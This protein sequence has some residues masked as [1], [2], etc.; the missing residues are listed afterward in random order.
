[1]EEV[2]QKD[3]FQEFGFFPSIIVVDLLVKQDRH[4]LIGLSLLTLCFSPETNAF[5]YLCH[6]C[7]E[8]CLPD[9]IVGHLYSRDH[10]SNYF[11]YTDPNV[12]SFSWVPSMD[13]RVILRAEILREVK[14]SGP[15]Q[16][17]VLD[18][19]DN[20]LK[21][22]QRSTY[23]DV[24]RTLSDNDKLL[25]LIEAGKPKRMM[26]QTYQKDNHRKHPLLGMQHLVECI[27]LGSAER[28]YY[29]CTLCKL[30][31]ATHMIIRHVLSFDHIFNY[32]KE[33]HPSTLMPKEC[34]KDYSIILDFAKQSEEIHGTA[35]MK[36][37][38]LKPPKFTSV[39]FTCYAK[40]LKDL[41][42]IADEN[43]ES[44]LIAS[45]K[46]GNKLEPRTVSAP[47][48]EL[49]YK[50]RCQDCSV[51]FETAFQYFKHL[52][53]LLH[54][55]M[56]E[57][58]FVKGERADDCHRKVGPPSVGLYK[59][60]KN[61][62]EQNNPAIGVSLVVTCISTE[63]QVEPL[64][65][66]FACEDCFPE[67]FLRKHFDSRKHLI[68]TLL[69]QNPW[70]LPF[71]WET[72]DVNALKS[73]A[74]EEEKERGPDEMMLKVLDMPYSMFRGLR[75]SYTEVMSSLKLHHV[76][77][78]REVPL[79]QT[80]RKLHQN[81]RFPLLG[82][83]FLVMYD[84]CIKQHQTAE[85]AFLCLLCARKLSNEE[86]YAH[87]F[88][89]EHVATFLNHFHPGSL[90]SS[91]DAETLLDL[92]KQAG[93]T[94]SISRVQIIKLDKPIWAPCTYERAISILASAKSRNG[95]GKLEPRIIP[96]VKLFPRKI[97]K[98][99]DK[100]HVKDNS[101]ANNRILEG[102]EKQTSEM[103]LKK[104]SAEVG[105]EIMNTLDV[106][107][108]VNSEKRSDEETLTQSEDE[109]K[110][111]GSETCQ[112]MKEEKTDNPTVSGETLE[113]CQNT[114]KAHET[115]ESFKSKDASKQLKDYMDKSHEK[116]QDDTCS[117]EE[118]EKKTGYKWQEL[119]LPQNP[120]TQNLPSNDQ[121][122][123]TTAEGRDQAS[124]NLNHQGVELWRY[125]KRKSREP[126][127]G[128]GALV[129]C[130]CDQHDPIYLCECCCLKIPEKEVISHVT[131]SGHQ[132][133]F[134][135]GLK[136]LQL[137][138]GTQSFSH[139]AA[140][141]EQDNG[142]GEAEVVELDE[143][144]YSNI[145][146]LNFKSAVQTVKAQQAQ[147]QDSRHDLS[148]TSALSAVQPMDTFVTLHAQHEV[149]SVTDDSQM[150]VEMQTDEDSEASEVQPSSLTGAVTE[151]T[152]KAAEVPADSNE[153]VKMTQ[154]KVSE[155]AANA[156]TCLTVSR[157]SEDLSSGPVT[158]CL[159]P[160]ST[161][162]SLK[163][164]VN[165]NKSV[166]TLKIKTTSEIVGTSQYAV[167]ST[168]SMTA[169]SQCST[170]PP[171]STSGTTK[172]TAPNSSLRASTS[173]CNITTPTTSKSRETAHRCATSSNAT[174]T[175]TEQTVG[176]NHSSLTSKTANAYRNSEAASQITVASQTIVTSI[177]SED[178]E[179]SA[180]TAF[181]NISKEPN[182]I[183]T[184][185]EASHSTMHTSVE[186]DNRNS[187]TMPSQSSTSRA[188]P[189]SKHPKVGVN[190]LIVVT[191]K[192]KQQVYC[193]LCSVKVDR[194]GSSHLNSLPHKYNYVKMLPGCTHSSSQLESRLDKIVA[195]L[196]EVEKN[197]G[198][199]NAQTIEVTSDV[200]KELNTLPKDNALQ[201]LKEMLKEKTTDTVEEK[202]PFAS[203]CD[204]SSSDDGMH[205]PQNEMAELSTDNQSENNPE[206]QTPLVQTPA[207]M[208]RP[209]GQPD[210]LAN[211]SKATDG[212]SQTPKLCQ[213]TA[214][215]RQLERSDS[216]LTDTQ[217]V[218]KDTQKTSN[219]KL[220]SPDPLPSAAPVNIEQQNQSRLSQRAEHILKH[221]ERSTGPGHHSASLALPRISKGQSTQGRSHLST[222]L[223]VKGHD[224][225]LIIGLSSVWECRG[226]S[227]ASFYL[228]ESCRETLFIR[229][230][231]EHMVSETHQL[232]YMQRE[233]SRYLWFRQLKDLT[234]TEKDYI[235]KKV[236][237]LISQAECSNNMDAQVI[238]LRPDLYNCVRTAPFSEALKLVHKIR[239]EPYLSVICPPVCTLQQNDQLPEN[240][241]SPEES[242]PTEK[243]STQALETDQRSDNEEGQ[244]TQKHNLEK[245][246]VVVHREVDK[247]RP[248][249]SL[250]DVTR[251]SS[252]ANS[253][254]SPC[255]DANT[256]HCSQAT[257]RSLFVQSEL[258]AP[259]SPHQ[260][261]IP[262]LQVKQSEMPPESPSFSVRPT[263][264]T[265]KCLPT[266]K[267]SAVTSL[268][269]LVRPD[270]NNPPTEDAL[271]AKRARSS[272]QPISHPSTEST[273]ESAP[274]S[275]AATSTL[276]PRGN[277][278]A[279][280]GSDEDPHLE[281]LWALLRERRSEKNMSACVSAPDKA[282]TAGPPVSCG[283]H[284][285]TPYVNVH[286][287]ISFG[288]ML[289]SASI[290][291]PSDPQHERNFDAQSRFGHV[292]QFIPH[293]FHCAA[294]NHD[295]GQ[296]PQR[297]TEADCTTH[298]QF[299]INDIITTRP[300]PA[301]WQFMGH[302][303]QDHTEV[304]RNHHSAHSSSTVNP[305]DTLAASGGYGLYDQMAYV[306]NEQVSGHL[307]SRAAAGY[308]TPGNPPAYNEEY[309]A[310]GFYPSQIYPQL[311]PRHFWT[312]AALAAGGGIMI[313]EAAYPGA[314]P[315]TTPTSSSQIYW[316]EQLQ[317]RHN[318]SN[319]EEQQHHNTGQ[320]LSLRQPSSPLSP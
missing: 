241:Q 51:C 152:F 211:G 99:V 116:S 254:V 68:H 305:T 153:D 223:S 29:L 293:P 196:A 229:D 149:Q 205:M 47:A 90:N 197:V 16:L 219:V 120:K 13:M 38:Q 82:L 282:S 161:G 66:C 89:R 272:L 118:E 236:V 213:E 39:N 218:P 208:E 315:F 294:T 14:Q 133:M 225:E 35:D 230:I 110:N 40:A 257:G 284:L 25:K 154:I 15:G 115:E 296:I 121:K 274:V 246:V 264:P 263:S 48:L 289:P 127:V 226:V 242:H 81:E 123:V 57:K 53:T 298:D 124:S 163:P 61:S 280:P 150:K 9:R 20:L 83:Q 31:L 125:L 287:A 75:P 128:L 103:T 222:S 267:R 191:C 164:E 306:R 37:V 147:Q 173:S 178:T 165:S 63:V 259:V 142:C 192:E 300:D 4:P 44:S 248:V 249:A 182:A 67:S 253:V 95:N 158:T 91:T 304:N 17:Q 292:S 172:L 273:C 36:Q 317:H 24:I 262:K 45:V 260:S 190:H 55:K 303:G 156:N 119:T 98:D 93:R 228:C 316:P 65:V 159:H 54:K 186:S 166:G 206:L 168:K 302:A 279:G 136:K 3:K 290:A 240:R 74:W 184:A 204:V 251:V 144:I 283:N 275:P 62:L 33:W 108:G 19:P 129:E 11:S 30:T 148:S 221:L 42:S 140:L 94:H 176:S 244:E 202:A 288:T 217:N 247:Q 189:S 80:Y 135:G 171:S 265:D 239:K 301:N 201:R 295:P 2:F 130:C 209:Q 56:L 200:Y 139:L 266:M 69:Y 180:K 141:F 162:N 143:E 100:G 297:H 175:T 181:L 96:S 58:Y 212:F 146:K 320:S 27:C 71:A 310:R 245:T 49:P 291:Y 105:A 41:E 113:S 169:I 198:S 276:L 101:Q 183:A 170:R 72:L 64:Y 160:N 269:S 78:K 5:F 224:N 12:L 102:S 268:E 131:G 109:S 314:G 220:F 237:L 46:P 34:Y 231:C 52:S 155:S 194:S 195:H 10:C 112:A 286:E 179:A 270:T 22:L 318:P 70:R 187:P 73:M 59:Y 207:K 88:S 134:L 43:K 26:I 6:A 311:E 227:L 309:I 92:A 8:K 238:L 137:P 104:I 216:E 32:F 203:P 277:K 28:R 97:L 210:L 281:D 77:L 235:F 111:G 86:C 23:L 199:R 151:P 122:E 138:P 214:E 50:L 278:D 157:G 312:S 177:K 252:E 185:P 258:R 114:D 145:S 232:R 1:M 250:L 285:D 87:V 319:T 85:V 79:I 167:T 18:L 307:S 271:P 117:N 7:E 174:T 60:L 313:N 107:S 76:L 234:N 215:M 84:L 255:P 188:K 132:K 243:Q 256:S 261:S 126:V 233:Y 21:N 299:P 193:Q 308:A 106:Q